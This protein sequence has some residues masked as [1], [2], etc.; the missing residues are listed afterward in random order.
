MGLSL[1]ASFPYANIVAH[2]LLER[3]LIEC[4]IDSRRLQGILSMGTAGVTKYALDKATN[5]YLSFVTGH[6]H[7]IVVMGIFRWCVFWLTTFFMVR[8]SV[9]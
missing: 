5:I 9:M 4:L 2:I 6:M 8:L 1:L 3:A 7:E